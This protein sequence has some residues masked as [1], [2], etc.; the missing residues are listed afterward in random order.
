MVCK[1]VLYIV[2]ATLLD[3]FPQQSPRGYNLDAYYIG[4][5]N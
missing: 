1:M 5:D 2:W 4:H 3:K